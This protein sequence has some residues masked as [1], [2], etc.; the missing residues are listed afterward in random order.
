MVQSPALPSS[1]VSI[2]ESYIETEFSLK[3]A[4]SQITRGAGVRD[5]SSTKAPRASMRWR[6]HSHKLDDKS[7]SRARNW[8]R[9]TVEPTTTS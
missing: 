3:W 6:T 5:A 4:E 2:W 7:E 1:P 8:I 9:I